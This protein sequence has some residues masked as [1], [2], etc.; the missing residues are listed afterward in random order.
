MDAKQAP[1]ETYYT[2]TIAK[3]GVITW[4][5]RVRD[6]DVILPHRV[7]V[8]AFINPWGVAILYLQGK[9]CSTRAPGSTPGRG[10]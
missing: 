7:D 9:R 3:N 8:P 6:L 2:K 10:R 4:G 5:F 1:V